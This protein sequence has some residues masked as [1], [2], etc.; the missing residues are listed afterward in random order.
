MPFPGTQI[1]IA[2]TARSW[3]W[4]QGWCWVTRIAGWSP[5]THTRRKGAGN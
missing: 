5:Y 3:S 1:Q 4:N 2:M